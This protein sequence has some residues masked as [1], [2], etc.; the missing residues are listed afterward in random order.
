MNKDLIL[1][2][3]DRINAHDVDGIADFFAID[4]VFIDTHD[5]VHEGKQLMRKAWAEY[6]ELFPD[7]KVEVEHVIEEGD[8]LAVFGHASATYKGLDAGPSN[9]WRL[10]GAWKAVISKGKIKL[11]QVYCDYKIIYDII[12]KKQ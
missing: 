6:F 12:Q 8:M 1:E 2:F 7:Y 3:M 4:H 11:W 10:P 9:F 5:T